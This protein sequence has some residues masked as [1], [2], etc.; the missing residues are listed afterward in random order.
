MVRRLRRVYVGTTFSPNR[1]FV[2]EEQ[3]ELELAMMGLERCSPTVESWRTGS[4]KF[5]VRRTA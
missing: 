5:E 3:V 1:A 4:K 2:S